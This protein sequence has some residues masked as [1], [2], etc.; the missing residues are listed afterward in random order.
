MSK[1]K[2]LI[3]LVAVIAAIP[4]LI[5]VVLHIDRVRERSRP[6]VYEL[7]AKELGSLRPGDIVLR[8]GYGLVSTM[9]ENSAGG[10]GVSHCGILT[11]EGPDFGVIHSISSD[12][13]DED[14]VQDCTLREFVRCAKPGSFAAVRCRVADSEGIVRHASRYLERRVPFDLLFDIRD[15]SKIFCSELIYLVILNASGYPIFDTEKMDYNFTSFFDR[16]LFE[17]LIDH[18]SGR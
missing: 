16:S 18:R 14:G 6:Q 5:G 15:S 2:A 8:M 9:L 3:A 4:V 13:A 7:T 11:G 12:L 10:M 17:A 1:K